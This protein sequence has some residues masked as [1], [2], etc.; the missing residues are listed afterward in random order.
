MTRPAD[1]GPVPVPREERP[2]VAATLWT[3][4]GDE[5]PIILDR[6][7][8]SSGGMATLLGDVYLD[9]GEVLVDAADQPDQLLTPDE[10]RQAAA[11][12]AAYADAADEATGSA[13]NPMAVSV[14]V[15][16]TFA[17]AAEVEELAA[18]LAAELGNTPHPADTVTAR[19]ALR[20]F[21]ER[22]AKS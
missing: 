10:A 14:S 8:F 17:D 21:R 13:R 19:A 9:G 7:K 18:Y 15:N 3:A 1:A 2:R 11:V 22:E 6:P 12:L 5:A 4:N 16:I 20:W